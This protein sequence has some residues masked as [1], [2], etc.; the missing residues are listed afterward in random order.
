[1]LKVQIVSSFLQES[2]FRASHNTVGKQNAL[3]KRAHPQVP[4]NTQPESYSSLLCSPVEIYACPLRSMLCPKASDMKN[5]T[6]KTNFHRGHNVENIAS[7]PLLNQ[8]IEPASPINPPP[9]HCGI[10][11][12]MWQ[13]FIGDLL[14]V[15]HSTQQWP[16]F[17]SIDALGLIWDGWKLTPSNKSLF[18]K[19]W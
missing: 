11:A 3:L 16:A 12:L 1:M 14:C 19:M 5:E 9:P 4:C 17:I 8:T 15:R 18:F 7:F 2:F 10:V 6:N 13:M